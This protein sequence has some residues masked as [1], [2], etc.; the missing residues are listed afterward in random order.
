MKLLSF[1]LGFIICFGL[2]AFHFGKEPDGEVITSN[3]LKTDTDLLVDKHIRPFIEL[4]EHIGMSL[5]V[6][7]GN[8]TTYYHYGEAE[9]KS[10]KLPNNQSIYEIGSITKTFTATLA[11]EY[12]KVN[13][14]NLNTPINDLLP[15]SIQSLEKEGEK[16][17]LGNVLN[18]SSGLPRLPK[19]IFFG[20]NPHNPYVHYKKEQMLAYLNKLELETAPGTKHE[21]SNYGFA[22]LGLMM[23]LHSGKSYETL[24]DEYVLK[25]LA[26]T[27]TKISLSESEKPQKVLPYDAKGRKGDIWD[28]GDF[29]AA[30]A[31]HATISDMALYAKAQMNNYEGSLKESLA[32]TKQ[33]TFDMNASTQIGLG[34]F[35]ITKGD[36]KLYF[37]NG[38]TGGFSSFMVVDPNS[39]KAVVSLSN[40]AFQFKGEAAS[41]ALFNELNQ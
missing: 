36:K 6:I 24:L 18:H 31:L 23:E 30:G 33:V 25:P 14:I 40:N 41:F 12:F 11:V 2:L 5:V 8:E 39:K 21:Y 13:K 32:K 22:L 19:D 35:I 17:T 3:P 29:K 16:I 15:D 9:K 28:L 4:K 37:H 7:D 27:E 1:I 38:G 20:W 10:G 34:W 26:L